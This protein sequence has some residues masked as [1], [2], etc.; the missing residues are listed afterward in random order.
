[1][2]VGW[3]GRERGERERASMGYGRGGREVVVYELQGQFDTPQLYPLFD[4]KWQVKK[5][6]SC[7][8]TPL[9]ERSQT[10]GSRDA[11][12]L[13]LLLQCRDV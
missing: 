11:H 3:K 12:L 2:D 10:R 5:K 9:R 1:M 13:S 8:F 7:I 4:C 6:R